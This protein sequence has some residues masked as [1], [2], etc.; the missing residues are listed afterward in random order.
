MLLQ[1]AVIAV[2]ASL[3][4]GCDS[5]PRTTTGASATMA[6]AAAT[7]AAV[8]TRPTATPGPQCPTLNPYGVFCRHAH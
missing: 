5:E 3:I 8:A 7:M 2:L 6:A 4:A 1:I